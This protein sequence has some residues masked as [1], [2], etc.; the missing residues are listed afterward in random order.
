[1]DNVKRPEPDV[2]LFEFQTC[3]N[4]KRIPFSERIYINI[5]GATLFFCITDRCGVREPLLARCGRSMGAGGGGMSWTR[6]GWG[7]GGGGVITRYAWD[8]GGG[9]APSPSLTDAQVHDTS[10]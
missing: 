3:L 6:G 9:D 5:P 2:I 4:Q 8:G 1:M 10:E 7:G